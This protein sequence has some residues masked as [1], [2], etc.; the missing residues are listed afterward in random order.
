VEFDPDALVGG[1][2]EAVRMAAE[3]M[4]VTKALRNA[5]LAHDDRDLM[6]SFGSSGPEVPVIVSAWR[7]RFADHA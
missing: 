1:V 4:H 6:Q 5:A 2:E 7:I 3:A